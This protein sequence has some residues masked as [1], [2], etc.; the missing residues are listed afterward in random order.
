MGRKVVVMSQDVLLDLDN[1]R[2]AQPRRM[3]RAEGPV[4]VVMAMVM[5]MIVAMRMVMIVFMRMGMPALTVD[6]HLAMAAAAGR[7]HFSSP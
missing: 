6:R 4:M 3:G 1:P 2:R 5:M 7:A